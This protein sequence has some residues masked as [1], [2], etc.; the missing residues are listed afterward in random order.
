M[1]LRIDSPQ[2]LVLP[3]MSATLVFMLAAERKRPARQFPFYRGWLWVGLGVMVAFVTVAQLWSSVV[4][5]KWLRQHRWLN[6]EEWGVIGG[7]VI[8]FVSNTFVAY[9]YHRCQHRFNLLW[10]MV[11]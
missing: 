1:D 7:I 2:T 4:P 8:W 9:W 10:R 11:H 6:G 3:V 5:K